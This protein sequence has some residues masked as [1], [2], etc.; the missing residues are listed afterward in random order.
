MKKLSA[1]KISL[2]ITAIALIAFAASCSKSSSGIATVSFY[3]TYIGSLTYQT[4]TEA[5]TI[6]IPPNPGNPSIIVMNTKTGLGSTYTINGNV[7]GSSVTIASQSI[8]ISG[9][10]Y[11]VTGSGFLSGSNLVIDY[12]FVSANKTTYDWDFNGKKQ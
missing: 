7:S 12:V 8:A 11:T 5:D 2:I 4:F 9:T 1:V 10:T 6:S 3:G